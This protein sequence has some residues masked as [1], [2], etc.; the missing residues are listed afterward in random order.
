MELCVLSDGSVR[1]GV[2]RGITL[3]V[4]HQMQPTPVKEILDTCIDA[5]GLERHPIPVSV[6]HTLFLYPPVSE[7]IWKVSVKTQ[8]SH[9]DSVFSCIS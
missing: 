1:T 8:S 7:K 5:L 3:R 9:S 6:I 2:A 4:L